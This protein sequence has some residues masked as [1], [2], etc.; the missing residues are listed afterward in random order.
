VLSPLE[1]RKRNII[2]IRGILTAV[3]VI[4]AL[5]NLGDILK[6]Q[7]YILFYILALV[8]S[9]FVFAYLPITM[10][11][12][13]KLHYVI[14]IL[15]II[16]VTLGAY[17]LA[18]L[19]FQ[20][21]MLIFFTVFISA[22]SRSVGLSLATAVAVNALYIYMKF[23][24]AES[25]FTTLYEKNIFLNIPFLFIVALHSSYLAEKADE[26]LAEKKKLERANQIL[27]GKVKDM[28]ADI[29]SVVDFMERVYDSFR[30]GVIVVDAGGMIR[31]F[32]RKCEGI[33][34]IKR[35][36]AVNMF[37]KEV[38]MLGGVGDIISDIK[39]KRQLTFDGEINI[40]VDGTEKTLIINTSY[41]KDRSE[42]IIGYL[43]TIRQRLDN[44]SAEIQK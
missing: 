22:L 13:A 6:S 24:T 20:F 8:A 16:F 44:I 18:Y 3:I 27:S 17:W 5:Y 35:V 43:C 31:Q 11:E 33:F 21:F 41:I 4:L 37:Y 9:N 2:Y 12:G 23:S 26:D 30:E 42:N 10:Y 15:D 28:N 1:Q 14:F 40:K 34:N 7:Q 32:S 19:D 39:L 38:N 25:G 36:K 29:E